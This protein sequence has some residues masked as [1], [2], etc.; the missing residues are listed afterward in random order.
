MVKAHACTY[1]PVVQ[2]GDP[3][4]PVAEVE[5]LCMS[6]DCFLSCIHRRIAMP[7]VSVQCC[8]RRKSRHWCLLKAFLVVSGCCCG[9]LGNLSDPIGNFLGV[10]PA[11]Q[12]QGCPFHRLLEGINLHQVRQNPVQSLTS[13]FDHKS[14]LCPKL[15]TRIW[16]LQVFYWSGTGLRLS[17]HEIEQR[18]CS[19]LY[20]E[21]SERY[22]EPRWSREVDPIQLIE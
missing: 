3:V 6:K 14:D 8:D 11:P 9:R 2:L 10:S 18:S 4:H 19:P 22:P 20:P 21:G 1:L 17:S 16:R 5:C 7:L 15:V 12:H 13:R